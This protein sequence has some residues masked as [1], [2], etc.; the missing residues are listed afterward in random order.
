M[1]NTND[2]SFVYS[3]VAIIT[4]IIGA[5]LGIASIVITAIKEFFRDKPIIKIYEVT[6]LEHKG[7]FID[8][9]QNYSF[10]PGIDIGRITI[11]V[12]MLIINVGLRRT[13][14][15]HSFLI[16][17]SKKSSM[18]LFESQNERQRNPNYTHNYSRL[19]EEV[20]EPGKFLDY[21]TRYE[22]WLQH[23]FVFDD[24]KC[25]VEITLAHTRTKMIIKN[26]KLNKLLFYDPNNEIP[27]DSVL[28][29]S[30]KIDKKYFDSLR[31][32]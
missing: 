3:I 17:K 6:T 26:I 28:D 11:D 22:G 15:V 24:L 18:K 29:H 13:S 12:H 19:T 27:I 16:L 20:I 4:G 10:E 7:G 5:V 25:E 32:T 8:K 21:V 1:S 14:I 30:K 23:D 2:L 31:R 9:P